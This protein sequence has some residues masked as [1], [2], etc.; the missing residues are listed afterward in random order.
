V[1]SDRESR[2]PDALETFSLDIIPPPFLV[3]FSPFSSVQ[4]GFP[5][6]AGIEQSSGDDASV[7]RLAFS[8]ST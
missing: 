8:E 7:A 1:L 4:F 2:R 6:V 3:L 5:L